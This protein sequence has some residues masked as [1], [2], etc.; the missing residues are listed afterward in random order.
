MKLR[1]KSIFR[2]GTA[3]LLALMMCFG[4]LSAAV[5]AA[6]SSGDT[7]EAVYLGVPAEIED[8]VYYASVNMKN[9]SNP[10]KQYSMGNAALRGSVSYKQKQPTDT[11]Y[12]PI[13]IVKDGKATALLEFMPMGYLGMYGFMMELEGVYPGSFNRYGSPNTADEKTVFTPTRTLTY[14]KTADGKIVYDGYNDPES[15]YKFDGGK[16]RPAGFGKDEEYLNIVDKYYSHLLALDVTPVMV[17]NDGDTVPVS[18]EDYNG[19]HAAFCHVFV[20]VMFDISASSG[21]QYARME[22]DWKTLE[23]IAEPEKN[24]QYMLYKAS[25]TST[26]GYTAESVS[27]FE[28]AYKE[29]HDALENVWA[30]QRLELSGSGFTAQPVLD[31]KTY[32]EAEQ[33]A[34]A[35]K[36]ADAING[37]TTTDK[38]ALNEVVERARAIDTTLYTVDSAKRMLSALESAESVLADSGAAQQ[39]VDSAAAELNAAID[40]LEA[41][42]T[43]EGWDGVSVKEPELTGNSAYINTAEELAWLSQQV[44]AGKS[45]D[46][47]FL[48]SDIDLNGKAWTAIGTAENPFTGEFYGCGHTVSNLVVNGSSNYQGLFGYVKGSEDT[49]AAVKDVTVQGVVRT[50]ATNVGGVIGSALYANIEN[51]NSNVTVTVDRIDRND[52]VAVVG[53]VVGEAIYSSIYHCT[54]SADITAENQEK[55]G[56][57][58]GYAS[59][60]YI[61]SSSNTGS[62]RA[63]GST[64]GIVGNYFVRRDS[65]GVINCFNKGTVVGNGAAVGGIIGIATSTGTDVQGVYGNL[66][67]R[68]DVTA[69]HTVGGIIGSYSGGDLSMLTASYSTGKITSTVANSDSVGALVGRMYSGMVFYSFALDGT[70]PELCNLGI[71]SGTRLVSSCAF[72]DEQWLK[73]DDFFT[74]LGS[75]DSSYGK[76]SYNINNGYPVLAHELEDILSGIK[77]DAVAELIAYKNNADYKG[78]AKDAIIKIKADALEAIG[79]AAD[80]VA[81]KAA[82]ADAKAALDAV[83]ND[84]NYGLDLSVIKEK[85]AAAKELE[86]KGG[87]LYTSE[88]WGSFTATIAG[89]DHL[90]EDGF[91]TQEKVEE[92]I[93]YLEKNTEGLSYRDADYSAVDAAIAKIPDDLSIYTDESV[94]AL[95]DAEAAVVRGKKITEQSEVDAMAK[96]IADAVSGLEKKNDDTPDFAKLE[97]GV[98]SIEFTMVKMNRSDLSMSNDAVNHTAKLTVKDGSYTLTVNFKG[99]HYL[100]R[101]GYLAKLS[102]YEDGYTYGEY[103]AVIGKLHEAD[104]ISVQK[105]ADG[106]D[107]SDEFNQPGGSAAGMKYPETISFPLVATARADKDGFVPLHVFVPVMEDISE[108]NGDQDVLMKLDI[109]SLKKTTENDPSFE[110]EKPEELSPAVDLTDAA[111]GVRVRADK[112]VFEEGVKLIVTEITSGADYDKAVSALGSSKGF[113]LWNV[114]VVSPDGSDAQPNGTVTVSYPIASGADT[115]ALALYRIN[116]SGGKTLIRGTVQDGYYTAVTKTLGSYALVGAASDVNGNGANRSPSTGE[117]APLVLLGTLA[118]VSAGVLAV[119]VKKRKD[120]R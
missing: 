31:L 118:A 46:C 120:A 94:K 90:I 100:N 32:T 28:A 43:A 9:A 4:V 23:R 112:G 6:G 60:C 12:R 113:K 97:D 74:A 24:V 103:G 65:K 91:G 45:F 27:A 106:T 115:S 17:K 29:V 14:Q 53:G 58:V 10:A 8:G 71:G 3:M 116:E 59:G 66:Y 82:L 16:L 21:D 108:G 119:C 86:T 89:I 57:I 22:V 70:A 18:A 55:A 78:L 49:K 73:S 105:N 26:E 81:V 42:G 38:S 61:R 72:H 36:L 80:E 85:L 44:A 101:F 2:R 37:L 52:N 84:P 20:P 110:P 41:V 64:G 99:L 92:Y 33:T 104:V 35:Q 107:V 40:A 88:S 50:T 11:D 51:I 83:P 13:V 79:N 48:N 114:R 39:A 34:M 47:V 96:A 30:K 109:A 62:I 67:N 63:G 93:G 5:T 111:T 7:K 69:Q 77:S 54:N 1:S 25:E 19:E 117:G 75:A 68:G 98:Y 95:R 87:D 56:G 15:D 102:Y 76:D